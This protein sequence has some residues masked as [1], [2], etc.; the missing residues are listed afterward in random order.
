MIPKA[1]PPQ[2]DEQ[3]EYP[4]VSIV[5]HIACSRIA[6]AL[7]VASVSACSQPLCS[8]PLSSQPLSSQPP[9][10]ARSQSG[11]DSVSPQQDRSFYLGIPVTHPEDLSG[12]WEAPDGH[13][14]AIGIHLVLD[15][16]APVEATTLVGVEQKWLGLQVGLYQRVK[17]EIQ[18]GDENLFSDS[19]RGGSVRYEDSRLTLHAPGY[20]LDL[21]RIPGDQWT[22]RFHRG[23]F[24]AVVTLAR[25][26]L[27]TTSKG[28]WFLGTWRNTSSP[29]TTCLHIAQSPTALLAWSDTLLAWGPVRFAPQIPK[30][31]YSWEHY[32]DLVKIQP[33][34]NGNLSIELGAYNTICCSHS[35]LAT[36]ADGGKAM[37]ADW[38]NQ[39]PHRSRWIKMPG[40]SCIAPLK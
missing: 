5:S 8:Q 11:A 20:D 28:A 3:G 32:G 23:D 15:A 9:I 21:H 10:E 34:R 16:T 31:P 14:G 24:D 6:R 2:F 26:M 13:G 33:A 1:Q 39:S 17:A 7:V 36:P 12:L 38:P 27:Q 29:Q 18:I 40:D 35:F 37:K 19:P 30:P 22:G 25:P 4:H